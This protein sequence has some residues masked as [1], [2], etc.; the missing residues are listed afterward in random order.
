MRRP[1]QV[2]VGGAEEIPVNISMLDHQEPVVWLMVYLAEYD[3]SKHREIIFRGV[4]IRNTEGTATHFPFLYVSL[5]DQL[6]G[7]NTE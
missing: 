1:Q 6:K 2:S 5:P 7:Q 3:C 4:Q